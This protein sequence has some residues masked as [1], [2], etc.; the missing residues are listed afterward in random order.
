MLIKRLQGR[1]EEESQGKTI[2]LKPTAD[3]SGI[4]LRSKSAVS[5]PEQ[6]KIKDEEN[7]QEP[8]R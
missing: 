1:R 4:S 8:S 3:Q 2:Q 5:N 6:N 7:Q